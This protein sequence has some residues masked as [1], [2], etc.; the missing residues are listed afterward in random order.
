MLNLESLP[1][2]WSNYDLMVSASML[3]YVPREE[4]VRALS[5]LRS[6]LASNGVLLL[7]VTPKNWITKLNLSSHIVESST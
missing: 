2:E 3:E 4:L 5:Q 6:R 7:F 1:G